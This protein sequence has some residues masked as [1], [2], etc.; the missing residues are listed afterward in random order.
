MRT[1][2]RGDADSV[3]IR[4]LRDS[5][6]PRFVAKGDPQT[7]EKS[8]MHVRQ[9][10]A[11]GLVA[12]LAAIHAGEA[13]AAGGRTPLIEAARKGDAMAVR[14]LLEQQP[15]SVNVADADG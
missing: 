15:A 4:A 6:S 2:R 8:T 9:V 3:L 5:A 13:H 1:R 14:A 7:P 12:G 10:V 11:W